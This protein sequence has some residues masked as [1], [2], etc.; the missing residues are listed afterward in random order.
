MCRVIG[1]QY[2]G[3]TVNALSALGLAWCG[4]HSRSVSRTRRDFSKLSV[5]ISLLLALA[6]R[7][8]GGDD[9]LHAL[10][11]LDGRWL[12]V[13]VTLKVPMHVIS[14][15][16]WTFTCQRLGVHLRMR[17]AV[18]DYYLASLP[19]MLLPGGIAGDMVRTWRQARGA[20]HGPSRLRGPIH[21]VL[22]ERGAGQLGLLVVLGAGLAMN[23]SL[24]ARIPATREGPGN[25]IS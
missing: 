20:S 2:C 15:A 24:L 10:A 13:A 16:R 1:C 3:R 19:N 25:C 6:L 7:V 14:A 8:A 22:N 5:E 23:V 21:G 17:C 9:V 18:S 4:W 11:S 12:L